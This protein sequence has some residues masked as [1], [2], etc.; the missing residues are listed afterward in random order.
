MSAQRLSHLRRSVV[1]VSGQ[2]FQKISFNNTRHDVPRNKLKS[3][4]LNDTTEGKRQTNRV[5]SRIRKTAF[6]T[7]YTYW[8]ATVLR[9]RRWWK[10]AGTK[11][12]YTS[13]ELVPNESTLVN[14]CTRYFSRKSGN[15][16]KRFSQPDVMPKNQVR[17]REIDLGT[18]IGFR[19]KRNSNF[20]YGKPWQSRQGKRQWRK[21]NTIL[22]LNSGQC[23]FK[24]TAAEGQALNNCICVRT[25]KR[26]RK[27]Q[28]KTASKK[29]KSN[30][31]RLQES[32]T[33]IEMILQKKDWTKS[34][35][36]KAWKQ[37][38]NKN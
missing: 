12:N 21:S 34:Q 10:R 25:K 6:K 26:L 31:W 9:Y 3:I 28:G 8:K 14:N 36:L 30:R 16:F 27:M 29:F 18:N 2:K 1:V 38:E 4:F 15:E 7:V 5:K 11:L 32:S 35:K 37:K 17:V 19:Q 33:L 22:E 24:K 23:M 13:K 20:P